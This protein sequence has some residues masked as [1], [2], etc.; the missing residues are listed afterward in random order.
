MHSLCNRP[1]FCG[2]NCGVHRLRVRTDRSRV[3]C[4]GLHLRPAVSEAACKAAC[5]AENNCTLWQWC[6]LADDP[7]WGGCWTGDVA[8]DKTEPGSKWV[9][10]I[11]DALL[12]STVQ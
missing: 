12:N 7:A 2:A 6:S 9:G 5:C 1:I 4:V 3:E 8:C 10:G 11:R